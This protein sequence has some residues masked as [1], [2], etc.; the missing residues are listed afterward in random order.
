MVRD[1]LDCH[2]NLASAAGEL[3]ITRQGLSKLMARLEIGRT[4]PS[5]ER[6]GPGRTR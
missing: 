1:A 2:D 6:S 3:G 5:R 4:D